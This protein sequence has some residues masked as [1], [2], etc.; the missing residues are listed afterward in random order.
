LYGFQPED[1]LFGSKVE[2]LNFNFS[3]KLCEF[4]LEGISKED[5]DRCLNGA[6]LTT[7]APF[8]YTSQPLV[9]FDDPNLVNRNRY[10]MDEEVIETMSHTHSGFI[11]G[12]SEMDVGTSNNTVLAPVFSGPRSFRESTNYYLRQ[13]YEHNRLVDLEEIPEEKV[14]DSIQMILPVIFDSF[15][16]QDPTRPDD[17]EGCTRKIKL[18]AFMRKDQYVKKAWSKLKTSLYSTYKKP[19]TLKTTAHDQLKKEL[20]LD[21]DDVFENLFGSNTCDGLKVESINYIL[22]NEC[23]FNKIFDHCFF[24]KLRGELNDQTIHD[25][26]INFLKKFDPYFQGEQDGAQKA[27]SHF[28]NDRSVKTPFTFLENNTSLIILLDQ[29]IKQLKKIDS[30]SEAN[31]QLMKNRLT[32]IR[33]ELIAYAQAKNWV[34]TGCKFKKSEIVSFLF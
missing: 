5:E 24:R 22:A 25:I 4:K 23:I 26:E 10:S 32:S 16:P 12:I 34:L 3:P 27:A 20:S 30:I 11:S 15:N 2:F 6:T 14:R 1:D 28:R 13:I 33:E 9:A 31:K 19:K 21:H 17:I 18:L 29:F 7:P 8:N